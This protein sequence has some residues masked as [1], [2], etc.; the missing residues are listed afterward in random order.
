VADGDWRTQWIAFYSVGM[1]IAGW[2]LLLHATQW[3]TLRTHWWPL[4]L[5]TALSVV[6]K[7]LGFHVARE[8]TPSLVGIVDLAALF[9]FGP[10]AGAW[11]AA[12]SGLAYLELRALRHH[13]FS[14]RFM[15]EHPLFSSGLKALMALGCGELYV[16]LGGTIAPTTVTWPMLIPLLTTLAVWFT[17]DHLAWGARAFLRAGASE[18]RDF[19]RKMLA[20]SI[21]VE[22]LPLPLS[23]VIALAYVSMGEPVFMLLALAL[24][25]SGALLQRF[26]QIGVD[27]QE[28]VAELAVLN[29]FGRA[30]VEAQ[31]EM[32]PLYELLY[33]YCCRTVNAPIFIL[34]L[35]HPER[36]LVD[37][38]IHIEHGKRQPR[39]TLPVTET[40]QWMADARE[41]L[42]IN[43]VKRDGLPFDPCVVGDV[44][45][46]V[47]VVPL[48]AGPEF[49]GALS[50]QSD[51][52]GA[53]DNHALNILSTIANQAAMAIASA[54][55]YEAE[56]R[57]ARQLSAIGDLSR[58]VAAILELDKLFAYVVELIQ[59]TF[60]YDHVNIFTVDDNTGNVTF[61]ASTNPDIQ[62][63]GLEVVSG[64]GIIGWVAQFGEPILANDVTR[65]PRYRFMD[66]LADT[67]AELV[68]PLK[69]E[70]HIVGVLDIQSNQ[71]D[72]FSAD[73]VFV[74][75]T[76]AAQV[77]IAVA[78]ARLYTARQE[79]AWVSTALLQVAEA[80][81]SLDSL[82]E[83][84]ETVVRITPML[85]GVNR[86]T[87]LL[88][89]DE[90]QE[91]AS[92]KGYSTD[93]DMQPL[94][95]SSRFRPGD[96]MLLDEL[97][98]HNQPIL[99]DGRVDTHLI[100]PDL[101]ADFHIE[102]LLALPLRAQAE[103]HG[104]MLVDYVQPQMQFTDRKRAVLSGFADQAA[105]AIANA[106]LHIA[107]REEAWVSTAL[108][109]VAQAVVSSTD[110]RENI[111]RITRLTPLLVG[112]DCCMVF[113]WEERQGQFTPYDAHGLGKEAIEAFHDLRFTAGE[114][115]LPDRDPQAYETGESELGTDFISPELLQSIGIES[116][117]A[118]P[119]VGQ[120][121]LLG[122]LVVGY[123]QASRHFAARRI[124]IIEG[125]AH[126]TAI[127]IENA[128]LHQASLEQER[129]A[130]EL[131][132]AR[133]IQISFLPDHCPD[134]PGWEIAA[135]WH[136]ARAVG[137][138]FYDFIP[139]DSKHLGLVIADVAD[140]GVPAALFMSLSRTL[141]RASSTETRSPAQ[142][143]QRVNKLM[144]T[145][146]T[147]AMFVTLFYGVLNW[148]TGLLTYARA[149]HN[150]PLLWRHSE[151]R[152]DALRAKGM[153]LGVLEDITLEER[154]A[155]MEPGDVL[156]LYTDGVTESINEQMED[157]G[158]RRLGEMIAQASTKPCNDIVKT[159]HAA[160]SEFVG[161][162]PQFDDY[163]LVAIK[164]TT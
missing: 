25:A 7:R 30:L 160:V 117:L 162:Q 106:R 69:V 51:E 148:R 104:A 29:E 85:A 118:V 9:V 108:L 158:E 146:T 140:K 50:V 12:S 37:I 156:V 92:A 22:L 112:V 94:F 97:R 57:R 133:E 70:E 33:E 74:V 24:I 13:L 150:L 110:L 40:M 122:A 20:H 28:H 152:M 79:E 67:Q 58:R 32:N 93:S 127:A 54:R 132:L 38:V 1:G 128:R 138:D 114:M 10:A 66:E 15:A 99:V 157:F 46:S 49:I 71:K 39:R 137:G 95:Y 59:E 5:F 62:E 101:I 90:L 42:L 56:Q 77:A 3:D 125:I 119:L 43:N 131:R 64:E 164:R 115:P 113:L 105:M 130:Q 121:E 98:M 60:H 159:I 143:L 111:S 47:L 36:N 48:L 18:L 141:V 153:A 19:L 103:L 126:Q 87:I 4:F 107:Q 34:E 129:T 61:R 144:T 139:L 161:N 41:P 17:I 102:H 73:D 83:I 35:M 151:S 75:Q 65:E 100:P 84:L 134:Y 154:T 81:G 123:A 63:C 72:T 124:R 109:Q 163:T 14:W 149:G 27:L 76:L 91:F 44:P 55:A 135:D 6:I 26:S 23:I 89:D 8:V 96:V 80:V 45:Q 2:S 78:D 68:V 136:A 120:G 147:S 88:W 53:F 145:E 52:A 11:V 31:L 16:R 82:D 116:A 155:T 86:C 21:L 142:I